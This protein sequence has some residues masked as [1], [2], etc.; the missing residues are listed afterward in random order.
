MTI[1]PDQAR[2]LLD[3]ATPGP[4]VKCRD[5]D[6]DP[7]PVVV[8]TPRGDRHHIMTAEPACSEERAQADT[9]LIAAAPDL[10]HTIAG[11]EWEYGLRQPR[12]EPHAEGELY[13]SWGYRLFAAK[14]AFAGLTDRGVECYI[15][16]RL[17]GPVEV[18]E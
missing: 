18:T 9:G 15:V 17:V 3:G 4:W 14:A 2:E 13:T 8:S 11:M 7:L 6:G 5:R 12:P 1:T 10:A 16:R